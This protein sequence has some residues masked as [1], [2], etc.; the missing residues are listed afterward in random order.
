MRHD[1]PAGKRTADQG[2]S[3]GASAGLF[4][5]AAVREWAVVAEWNERKRNDTKRHE[6]KGNETKRNETI[7]SGLD[8]V[9][10]PGFG[11][12]EPKRIGPD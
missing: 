10:L 7:Q 6:T 9:V 2:T 11:K 8:R 3:R 5:A 4:V 12:R 1:G